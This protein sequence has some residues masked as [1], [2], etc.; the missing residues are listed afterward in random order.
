MKEGKM[1]N[2]RTSVD[3]HKKI[4]ALATIKGVSLNN[5]VNEAIEDY[6]T[7]HKELILSL[8]SVNTTKNNG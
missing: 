5:A 8:F 7:K 4:H 3:T 1:I 2:I 6:I